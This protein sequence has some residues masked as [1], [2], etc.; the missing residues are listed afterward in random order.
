MD[1]KSLLKLIAAIVGCEIAGSIGS[2]F[3]MPSIPTWYAFLAKPAFTP[4]NWVFAPVWTT[5]FFLMGVSLY[6]I[7]DKG[8]QKKEARLAVYVFGFQ[9][10][11]NILW[12]F[13]F[14]GL[15]N[16][17]LAF[18]EIIWLWLFILATIILFSRISKKASWLLFPYFVWVTCASA[19][20][21]AVWI[22]NA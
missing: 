21:Y 13:L 10:A 7:W 18:V 16:P 12:S 20:N 5:L 2:L 22:L 9:F 4:P 3:T 8:L 19:L 14:F 17:F 6:L 15:K 11:L 1:K